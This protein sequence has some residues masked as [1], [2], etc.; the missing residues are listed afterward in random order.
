[1]NELL[2]V[3]V[4]IY[5]VEKYLDRCVASLIDQKYKNVEI[6][7]VDDGSSDRS[8]AICDAWAER[9]TRIIVLHKSNGGLAD[10]RNKGISVAS[11]KYIS[12]VDGDDSVEARMYEIM[13]ESIQRNDAGICCCGKNK[14]YSNNVR[15]FQTADKEYVF[16][17]IEAL[18]KMFIGGIVDESVC[19]KIFLKDLFEGLNFPIGEINEDLPLM[20]DLFERAQRVSHVGKALYN[21]H[22]NEGSITRSRYSKKMSVVIAHIDEI[23]HRWVRKYP[24][25]RRSVDILK[26]RYSVAMLC[27]LT[28][29]K[30]QNQFNDDMLWY[31]SNLKS[32]LL[33]Y[34]MEK[35]IRRNDK[36]TA[37]S[38][39]TH[40]NKMLTKIYEAYK[41]KA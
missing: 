1:M 19:D 7:L 24:E 17:T 20:P 34:I 8:G 39:V 15:L 4:P 2:S 6:I 33:H 26:C 25:L 11:G 21:Y 31:K 41:G 27:R 37:I 32:N 9:D 13:M 10:A 5:N 38:I 3:I 36:I 22:Q 35:E 40:T 29:K 28:D 12:F 14:V 23:E 30:E 16:N 18:E